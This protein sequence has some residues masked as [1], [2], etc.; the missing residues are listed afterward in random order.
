M[1]NTPSKPEN[2]LHSIV[3]NIVLPAVILAKL[4]APERL[5]PVNGLLLGLAFPLGYGVYDFL[6]RR[7]ANV[8][9]I[10]GF[11]SI[12]LTGG[13]GLM[14][15]DGI[16]FAGKEAAIPALIGI[17]T[18]ASLKTRTPLV[19]T[20]LYNETLIDVPR[21][22]QALLIRG[23]IQAFDRLLVHTTWFLAGSFLLSASLN[24]GL[25]IVILKSP[26]GT[27]EFNAELGQMTALSYPVIVLPCLVVTFAALWHLVRG[28]RQLTGL[29][30]D[31]IF[32]NHEKRS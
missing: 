20:V 31:A 19:R 27:P 32:R 13:F 4:S 29:D 11:V 1:N 22:D 21:V 30:L 23:N 17:F 28:I 9:A 6:K 16:W 18:V 3:F 7:K 24:F 12:L 14:Q 15:L 26:A 25:A 2:P 5:G 10:L 8:F